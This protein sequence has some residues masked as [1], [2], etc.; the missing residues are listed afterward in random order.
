MWTTPVYACYSLRPTGPG[1]SG[2]TAHTGR[3]V[4]GATANLPYHG[5]G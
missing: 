5:S 3:S 4:R 1:R 2:A